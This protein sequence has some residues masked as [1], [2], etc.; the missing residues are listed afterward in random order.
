MTFWADRNQDGKRV[1]VH[2]TYGPISITT[3]EDI[4]HARSF[5]GELGRLLDAMEHEASQVK[6]DA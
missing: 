1:N 2:T 5:W 4:G 3:A 6:A